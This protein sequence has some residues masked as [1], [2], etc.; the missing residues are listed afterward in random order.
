VH[1]LKS[2]VEQRLLARLILVLDHWLQRRQG[3]FEYTRKSN[4]IFRISCERLRAEVELGDG[5][6]GRPGDPVL[7]L[8]LWNEQIPA[9]AAE[10]PSLAWGRQFDRCFT[11]SLCELARFLAGD[12]NFLDVAIIRANVSVGTKAQ[13]VSLDRILSRHGFETVRDPATLTLAEHVRRFGENILYWLLTLACNSAAARPNKFWRSRSLIYLSRRVLERKYGAAHDRSL[14]SGE[15]RR[16]DQ[17]AS[18]VALMRPRF[19]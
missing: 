9:I 2:Q 3:I 16:C 7:Q 13:S 5:T 18:H 11:Q 12:P 14:Y 8:H 10:G 6:V 1:G 4:C 15:P 17:Q 19:N